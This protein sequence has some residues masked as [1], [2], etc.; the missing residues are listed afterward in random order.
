MVLFPALTLLLAQ[1]QSPVEQFMA[2]LRQHA[3]P[4]TLANNT[5]SGPGADYLIS[6]ADKAQFCLVGEEHGMQ[7]S[8]L[9]AAA[10]LKALQPKGY[11]YFAT[12]IGGITADH[13]AEEARKTSTDQ[14]LGDFN[15]TY[16]FSLPFYNWKEE[17]RLF[18]AGL[19][20][21]SDSVWG[22]DQEFFF[23]P[24]Y[25]FQRLQDLAT[26][27]DAKAAVAKYVAQTGGELKRSVAEHNPS[28]ALIETATPAE[29]DALDA[30]FMGNAQALHILG[31]L[32]ESAAI[33]Q[34]NMTGHIYENNTRRGRLLKNHFMERYVAAQRRDG[35][36]PK[37]FFKFGSAHMTRGRNYINSF[38]LGNMISELA[39]SQ[40]ETS[41][42]VL[43]F[44]AGGTY[45]KYFPFVGNEADKQKKLDA[46]Q[47]YFFIDASP[48]ISLS[49][50]GG[51]KVLD[52]KA[53]RPMVGTSILPALPNGFMDLIFGFD[54][55]LIV[56][57]AHAST[58][59]S[60]KF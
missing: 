47:D 42:H 54:A 40:G 37:V 9:F 22:L 45:N 39:A 25:L 38:D 59:Y 8:P 60:L 53:L 23:S 6:E 18:D 20:L 13:L 51:W 35:N 49:K 11:R 55:V 41:F 34:L 17:G 2:L 12:E 16:P 58:F 24:V 46:T 7:E 56:D 33:Y 27:N 21:G 52:L 50:D 3:M 48:L 57:E 4:I 32:R 15:A 5:L 31:E 30:A 28:I 43:V 26:T 14:A 44:A 10:Y 1:V 36:N 19:Q 29:F